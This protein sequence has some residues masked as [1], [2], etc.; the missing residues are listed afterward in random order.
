MSDIRIEPLSTVGMVTLRGDFAL[1]GPTLSRIAGC[2]MPE[3]RLSAEAGGNR[4]M[5]MSPDELLLTCARDDAAGL[6]ARLTDAFGEGHATA[7]EVS[8]ARA[9]F[10]LSGDG[11]ETMLS[12]LMPVDF[13][14]LDP[15][16]VRRTRM[17][18]IPAAIWRE[19][20]GWR[21][22]C[23]RSVARYAADLLD[24]ARP[25]GA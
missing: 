23:F 17:A 4:L 11:V 3:T 18:Q 24:G 2:A 8:D 16:E 21:L 5:W 7:V 19:P 6:A 22:M 15:S 9:V 12:K 25:V 20:D 10:A 13:D 14:R 1:L